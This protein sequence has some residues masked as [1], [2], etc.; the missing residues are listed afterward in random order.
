MTLPDVKTVDC[1][2]AHYLGIVCHLLGRE[3]WPQALQYYEKALTGSHPTAND[4]IQWIK[5]DLDI[6]SPID[7]QED[8]E[9]VEAYLHTL[10]NGRIQKRQPDNLRRGLLLNG[11]YLRHQS[12]KQSHLA[13]SIYM[14]Y[15]AHAFGV[16]YKDLKASVERV[17][18]VHNVLD[19]FGI[20]IPGQ[21]RERDK[22]DPSGWLFVDGIQFAR[23][24]VSII[25][26]SSD[27]LPPIV[28][29]DDV[30][31][32]TWL[33]FLEG[34]SPVAPSLSLEVADPEETQHHRLD[35][36]VFTPPWI[37]ETAYG[38]SMFLA[39]W[40][41]KA[42]TM[43]DGLP[44]FTEP[45]ITGG[46]S[47]Q[48]EPTALMAAIANASG[49][50]S[51]PDGSRAPHSRLEIVVHGVE[52]AKAV[53][54][55][56]LFQGVTDYLIKGIELNIDSGLYIQNRDGTKTN[57]RLNDPTTDS[58][59]SAKVLTDHYDYAA[60]QFP[61][62]YRVK[63]LLALFSTLCQARRDGLEL[64]NREQSRLL[65]KIRK[66]KRQHRKNSNTEYSPKPFHRGGCYCQGGVSG[67]TTATV[68][69]TS[70]K[71][72]E[73]PLN[74]VNFLISKNGFVSPVPEG[75][76]GPY[77]PRSSGVAL[78]GGVGGHGFDKRTTDVYVMDENRHQG[79]RTY[80]MNITG[81]KVDPFTG[82][83]I[84]PD[85]PMAHIYHN[86]KKGDM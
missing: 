74:S 35:K 80:Y 28:T 11:E 42:F 32:A 36:K 16:S 7:L 76:I 19:E 21:V 33:A 50:R 3:Y 61:V 48:W 53:Y 34:N 18:I 24:K 5:Q 6:D 83:T 84:D 68:V 26:T 69:E 15:D 73:L 86:K 60:E 72:F 62:F 39:D 40:L 12:V 37:G 52:V 64:S 8:P 82:H 23:G 38:Q 9:V 1:C 57:Y 2:T 43:Y 55:R 65:R 66:I 27:L 81:Q 25:G 85:H 70:M 71:Q 13:H 22:Q 63:L 46:V 17:G 14:M 79:K 78:R 29:Q 30:D 47:Q 41:M 31:V 20:P 67:R 59:A 77:A 75:A 44:S 49:S 4:Y 10:C 45:F 58:G 56:G 51:L 54:R